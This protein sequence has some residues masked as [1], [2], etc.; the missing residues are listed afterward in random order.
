MVIRTRCIRETALE[1]VIV[2]IAPNVEAQSHRER[3]LPAL[4]H[5]GVTIACLADLPLAWLR[6]QTLPDQQA[7]QYRAKSQFHREAGVVQVYAP[8]RTQSFE[9]RGAVARQ[10]SPYLRET[11]SRGGS[12]R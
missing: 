6:N 4:T 12:L 7:Q 1:F 3:A 8:K 2:C 5:T 11:N 10:R 9:I